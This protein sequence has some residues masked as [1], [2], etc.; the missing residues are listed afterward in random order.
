[1]LRHITTVLVICLHSSIS[2]QSFTATVSSDSILIGNYIELTFTLKNNTGS[3]EAPNLD[4]F[5]IIAGPN[6]SKSIQT[7]NGE[8]TTE[9]SYSYYI[10]PNQLG[11]ITIA[12]A[13]LVKADHTLETPPI[14]INIFSNPQ[15]IIKNPESKNSN[16]IFNF[17]DLGTFKRSP[18]T[19]N[20]PIPPSKSK[21]KYKKI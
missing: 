9:T 18:S 11:R 19:P 16:S 17:Q 5:E 3:F 1:M 12:P 8:S 10:K 15:N 4:E 7:I 21:R 2:G 20:K 13:Y 6:T 14:E